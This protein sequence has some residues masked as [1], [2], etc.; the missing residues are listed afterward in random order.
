MKNTKQVILVNALDF[1]VMIVIFYLAVS[2]IYLKI[3]WFAF[4]AQIV[5]IFM[6][7]QIQSIKTLTV[8]I[9]SEYWIII[10]RES[11]IKFQSLGAHFG[12]TFPHLFVQTFPDCVKKVEPQI[13]TARLFG[14]RV[15]GASL[16]GPRMQWLRM[17]QDKKDLK[18]G[19][20][21]DDD[22]EEEDMIL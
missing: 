18:K 21:D 9:Y 13:Y 16:A 3:A 6:C 4:S 20:D 1:T 2:M 22:E 19:D 10:S 15:H 5:W 11:L 17:V 8:K 14:F 7:R 12:T